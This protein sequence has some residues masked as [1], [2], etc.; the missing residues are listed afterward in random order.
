MI[1]ASTNQLEFFSTS[2]R[3]DLI[4]LYYLLIYLFNDGNLPGINIYE[5]LDRN[6][7]FKR[8]RD[9][10]L[11]HTVPQLCAGR[12]S[13]LSSFVSQINSLSFYDTPNYEQLRQILRSNL[14]EKESKQ[15]DVQMKIEDARTNMTS[16]D[17]SP[18]ECSF[19]GFPKQDS[20]PQMRSKALEQKAY[21]RSPSKS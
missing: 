9:T 16:G 14:G 21:D 4:S 8:I 3:D 1:F 19:R 7:S 10:K 12:A 2:R 11:K 15:K 13:Q 6:E 18:V 5:E 20:S 17:S